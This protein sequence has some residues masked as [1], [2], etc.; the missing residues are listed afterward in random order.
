MKKLILILALV[1]VLLVAGL[2]WRRTHAPSTTDVTF[3]P[4]D[5]DWM[6]DSVD[7]TPIFINPYV[8]E[9]NNP[10]DWTTL[11]AKTDTTTWPTYTDV[12]LGFTIK[13]PPGWGVK[14]QWIRNDEGDIEGTIIDFVVDPHDSIAH[15]AFL[16]NNRDN[17][18]FEGDEKIIGLLGSTLKFK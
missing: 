6:N 7:G 14:K 5:S 15:I 18:T 9:I 10:V 12:T 4:D 3:P 13:Y 1:V 2:C 11:S 16:N 17:Y 8:V